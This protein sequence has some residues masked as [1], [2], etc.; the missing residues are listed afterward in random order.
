MAYRPEATR[1]LRDRRIE[2]TIADDARAE[3]RKQDAVHID[4]TAG[5]WRYRPVPATPKMPE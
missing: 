3:R 5:K 2:Y 4:S 1:P